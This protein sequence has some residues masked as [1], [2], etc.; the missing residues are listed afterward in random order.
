M[1]TSASSEVWGR[2]GEQRI[3]EAASVETAAPRWSSKATAGGGVFVCSGVRLKTGRAGAQRS[4]GSVR[5]NGSRAGAGDRTKVE[6]GGG[7]NGVARPD[8]FPFLMENDPFAIADSVGARE[9]FF[10]AVRTVQRE[11]RVGCGPV[12]PAR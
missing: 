6:V 2:A 10:M 1:A 11:G 5:I 12:V 8:V 3:A 9:H 7:I 4:A